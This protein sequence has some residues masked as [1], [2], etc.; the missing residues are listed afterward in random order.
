MIVDASILAKTFVEE[1]DS[2][3]VRSLFLALS[4]RG[5]TLLSPE[6]VKYELGSVCLRLARKGERPPF[7]NAVDLVDV[8]TFDSDLL[9]DS[10]RVSVSTRVTF[11]DG[12]YVALARKMRC[13]LWTADLELLK[14][15]PDDAVS[16]GDLLRIAP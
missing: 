1:A 15:C 7:T 11:Y 4:E 14:R 5:D 3:D 16:T 12:C 13:L 8:V 10:L 6:L 2:E 9:D